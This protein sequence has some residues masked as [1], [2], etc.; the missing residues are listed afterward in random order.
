MHKKE[1]LILNGLIANTD[2]SRK[3]LPHLEKAFFEQPS[4]NVLFGIIFDFTTK[5]HKP[6][7][8]EALYIELSNTKAPENLFEECEQVLA[9]IASCNEK[10]DLGWLV[11]MTEGWAKRQKLFNAMKDGIAALEEED[12]SQF[13]GVI[14]KL[15]AAVGY[16]FDSHVGHDFFEDAKERFAFYTRRDHKVPFSLSYLNEITLGGVSA[17]TLNLLL[18]GVHVGKTM[19]LCSFATDNLRDGKNVLYITNEMAEEEI[20]KRID[21]N[22]LDVALDDLAEMTPSTFDRRIEAA[23][24]KY[25][26]KVVIKE[27]PTGA[28]STVHFDYLMSELETKK[29]FKPDVVY[30]DYLNICAS[31]RMKDASNSY[32]YI[33]S[34]AMELRG[35]GV[36]HNVPIWSAT[37]LNR[38]NFK[39]SD[40]DMDATSES[41]A[42]PMHA[43]FMLGLVTSE[44]FREQGLIRARQIKNRYRSPY[45]CPSFLMNVD[46]GRQRLSD[47][48][49][50]VQKKVTGFQPPAPYTEKENSMP[51]F[52]KSIFSE[53]D[54]AGLMD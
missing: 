2:Y 54:F 6:P 28:A 53:R 4:E 30:I 25:L 34:V 45:M 48:D 1:T 47:A 5:Y 18:A 26:G 31:A 16:S 13:S 14:E 11:D 12:P 52:D 20:A 19:G 7:T 8:K 21:A 51:I 46:Y 44:E 15:K 43:D 27:F 33:G 42:V 50:S 3:V 49:E 41:F 9:Q 29:N 23:R 38:E 22:L 32:R 39:K 36:G 35:F 10:N 24:Q 37:Q 17:K 40:F